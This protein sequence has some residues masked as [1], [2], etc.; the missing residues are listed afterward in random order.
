VLLGQFLQAYE[1]GD[2][3]ACLSLLDDGVRTDAGGKSEVRRE[4]DTL[5][6]S[7]DL[8]HVK[9][10]SMSWSRDGEFIRGEGRYRA[11]LMRKGETLLRTQDGK[12]R[13]ELVRRGNSAVI[14]ELYY[15]AGR[16]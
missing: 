1:R 8:R 3:Q 13:V 12:L 5:F 14:N 10:L 9:I 16:S 11:T 15:L 7:T 6:R 4:Y 2:I